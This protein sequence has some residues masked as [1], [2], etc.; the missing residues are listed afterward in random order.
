M[1]LSCATTRLEGSVN[2]GIQNIYS[3]SV[4]ITNSAGKTYGSGTIIHNRAGQQLFVL[5]AA[6]VVEAIQKRGEKLGIS[7]AFDKK[8]RTMAVY[9]IDSKRDLAVLYS[10]KKEE[11]TGPSVRI[12]MYSPNI[13]DKVWVIGA[14]LGE[15][16]TVTFGVISNFQTYKGKVLYRTTA[17]T[18]YGNSGGGMFDSRG[19]L[20]GVAHGILE[21]QR[22]IFSSQ[23]VPGGFFFVGLETI[24]EFM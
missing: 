1:V 2:P 8:K 21:I 7:T 19:N 15:E 20:V 11:R 10:V 24:R 4:T 17:A 12:S 3:S 13:G 14:P 16:R 5:T 22:T 23:L 6:H 18:Y 9:K